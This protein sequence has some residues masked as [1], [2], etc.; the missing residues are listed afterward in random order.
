LIEYAISC[1]LINKIKQYY[2]PPAWYC[3]T[4]RD[5]FLC[6][7][8]LS[9]FFLLWVAIL[10]LFRFLPQGIARLLFKRFLFHVRQV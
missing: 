8:F 3:Q 7:F 4:N 6:L 5:H 1:L 10:C 2:I 9:F